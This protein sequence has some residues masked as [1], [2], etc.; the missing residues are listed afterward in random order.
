MARLYVITN[1]AFNHHLGRRP[2]DARLLGSPWPTTYYL[3]DAVCPPVL[4][5]RSVLFEKHLDPQLF[6]AG[7]HF[8]AEWSFLLAEARHGFCEYPFFMVSSR[9]Y[10]K[11]A[12][13]ATDLN[14]EWERLFGL[15]AQY[16]WGYLPSYDRDWAWQDL[17][18]YQQ[19]GL[20]PVTEAGRALVQEMYG[21]D[22]P[23]DYGRM[24][25]FFCNYIGFQSR[26]HLLEYVNFYQPLISRFFDAA[27]T[28]LLDL[29]Q[30]VGAA[31]VYRQEKP[32]TFFLELVSHL[33][34]Y[35]NRTPFLGL[36]YD[37]YSEIDE[38]RATRRKLAEHARLPLPAYHTAYAP[39]E[40]QVR[41][42]LAHPWSPYR[43]L[44][45]GLFP[46][47]VKKLWPRRGP[48]LHR[49]G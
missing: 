22:I 25:D 21:V 12:R 24:S 36:H 14:R 49:P 28:P 18:A 37:G 32:F 42:A 48:A 6:V 40:Y 23:G 2:L 41:S 33:F 4:A 17:R 35:A 29:R 1:F 7:K 27:F 46:T 47:R 16:G 3:I 13:L 31:N 30:F 10:E 34:F 5:G 45:D 19:Q 9:F 20:L 44:F 26:R 39:L 8:L 15:L 38:H 11:N 43:F